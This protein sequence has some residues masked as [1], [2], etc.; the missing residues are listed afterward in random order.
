MESGRLDER[1]NFCFWLNKKDLTLNN[2][3][4]LCRDHFSKLS[5][6]KQP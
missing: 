1:Y 3:V 4:Y 2:M 5:D 6:P